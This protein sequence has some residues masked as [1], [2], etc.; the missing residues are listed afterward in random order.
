MWT[1][2]MGSR[3]KVCFWA[4]ALALGWHASPAANG[5]FLGRTFMLNSSSKMQW[6][7]LDGDVY[8]I[9]MYRI[10][11]TRYHY[12]PSHSFNSFNFQF[13]WTLLCHVMYSCLNIDGHVADRHISIDDFWCLSMLKFEHAWPSEIRL[14]CP[15]NRLLAQNE[16]TACPSP[17][18]TRAAGPCDSWHEHMIKSQDRRVTVP[19]LQRD[20]YRTSATSFQKVT[21]HMM[22]SISRNLLSSSSR[23]LLMLMQSRKASCGRSVPPPLL[24]SRRQKTKKFN[25]SLRWSL[26]Q[27]KSIIWNLRLRA[28]WSCTVSSSTTCRS[29]LQIPSQ[30]RRTAWCL[31][32]QRSCAMSFQKLWSKTA[33]W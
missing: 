8:K 23:I 33:K 13:A 19:S 11:I 25:S 7:C 10:S 3:H 24:P 2:F 31:R 28:L 22:P 1:S 29:S 21:W 20:Q 26:H 6:K 12:Q 18:D 15:P 17:L 16:C 9:M 5:A 30:S 32:G 14:R 27:S 4:V